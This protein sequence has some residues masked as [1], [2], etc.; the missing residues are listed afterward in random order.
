[1]EHG[2]M[3]I[4]MYLVYAF[5]IWI[6]VEYVVDWWKKARLRRRERDSAQHSVIELPPDGTPPV[7]DTTL[8]DTSAPSQASA[9]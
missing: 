5:A 2:S 9:S 1:M 6:Q 8:A 3:S 7:D 4:V